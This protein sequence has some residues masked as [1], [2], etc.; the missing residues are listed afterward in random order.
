MEKS[1]STY[2]FEITDQYFTNE[3]K[4]IFASNLKTLGLEE[5]IWAVFQCLFEVGL[6]DTKPVVLKVYSESSLEGAAILVKCRA[7]GKSLFDNAV[8]AKI[9][10]WWRIPCFLWIKFGACM[11]M[12]SNPGFVRD[13]DKSGEVINAMLD[14]LQKNT[15]LTIVTDHIEVAKSY[16]PASALPALPQALV[17]CSAMNSIADYTKNFKN[18]RRKMKT[19]RNKGGEYQ[20]VR[21]SIPTA[22]IPALE[23]CFLSTQ[24][25][26]IFY[27]PYQDLYLKAALN[28]SATPIDSVHYFIATIDGEFAG[29][30]AAIKTG[31]CLNALHGA[32]DRTRKTN[33]HA[34]DILFVKMTEFAIQNNLKVIDFGMVLNHTK[35]KMLNRSK[36]M[37]YLILS[38][39]AIINKIFRFFLKLSKIQGS[40]QMKFR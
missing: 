16:S 12:M 40:S 23:R 20:Q 24:D 25:Q 1:S 18:I 11:D 33:H 5:N 32:F 2:Q 13:P 37:C 22:L 7:Y 17:D 9:I 26:S 15:L 39:Y 38:K 8:V 31:H 21:G 19:F 10:D 3:E 4:A 36:E 29:Y 34:Y 14:Y 30:Q 28:T 6:P 27:L 35:Q